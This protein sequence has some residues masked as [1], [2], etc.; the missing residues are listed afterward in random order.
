L[1]VVVSGISSATLRAVKQE[2]A[3]AAGVARQMRN[4]AIA[5]MQD[6]ATE[7][8]QRMEAQ[9]EE[10]TAQIVRG[11][12]NLWTTLRQRTAAAAAERR[13]VNLWLTLAISLGALGLLAAIL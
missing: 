10:L 11:D 9:R 7:A 12:D 8:A 13:R 6:L 4:D 2:S 3:E 1:G 5:A